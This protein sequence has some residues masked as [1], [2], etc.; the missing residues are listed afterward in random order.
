MEI[1]IDAQLSPVLAH[2]IRESFAMV[3]AKSMISL[4]LR[5]SEDDIIFQKAREQKAVIMSKDADF[6][7]SPDRFGAPPQIVWITFGNTSNAR[8]KEILTKHFPSIIEMLER[9]EPMIEIQG[10]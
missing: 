6:I 10:I 5:D 9:G 8:M 2:W 4:N 7:R 1:W 3:D